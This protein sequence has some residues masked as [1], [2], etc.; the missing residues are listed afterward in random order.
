M[1][2]S[3][4]AAEL[5]DFKEAHILSTLAA[6]YAENGDFEKAIEWSAKAVELGREEEHAQIE[7]LEL[8]L[9]SYR[10]G[11]AWREKQETEENEIPI[12]SPDELIDT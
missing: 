2:L 3:L 7:Q 9:E 4:E 5:S 8:E 6:S 11:E 10:K 12:L 1:E